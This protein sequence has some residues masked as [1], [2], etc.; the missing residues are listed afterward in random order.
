MKTN[1][2]VLTGPE[3]CGKSTLAQLLADHLNAAL[4]P[5]VAREFLHGKSS[6]IEED[7]LEIARQQQ[8]LELQAL[9]GSPDIVVCD[10]DLLVIQIW[11][12]V[13][14]GRCNP[15]ITESL[16]SSQRYSSASKLYCLC[17][18]HVPW[19]PDPLR[20]NPDNRDELFALYLEKLTQSNLRHCVVKGNPQERLQQVLAALP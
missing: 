12:E 9:T 13:K 5:E 7:L 20:E 4:V 17:D 2:I 11:S 6:Y 1:I 18:Y 3:S 19:Q 16:D 8:A 14:Y 15:W 10:T